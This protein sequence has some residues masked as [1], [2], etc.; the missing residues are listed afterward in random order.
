M[1]LTKKKKYAHLLHLLLHFDFM[2][3]IV[4]N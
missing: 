3:I 1:N 4:N 2:H